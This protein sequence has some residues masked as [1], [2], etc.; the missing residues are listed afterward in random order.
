MTHTSVA[1]LFGSITL[2]GGVWSRNSKPSIDTFLGGETDSGD[3]VEG[4]RL[5]P[6]WRFTYKIATI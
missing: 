1:L 2:E 6:S 5:S 4:E 3:L